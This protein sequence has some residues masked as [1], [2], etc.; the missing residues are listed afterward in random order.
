MMWSFLSYD[1]AKRMSKEKELFGKGTPEGCIASEA[2][3]NA[4]PAGTMI[5]LLTLGIPGDALSAVLLGV[6]TINGIYPGPL[7]L[8]KEPVLISTIYWS[9]LMI[10]IVSFI[11][12][13]VWLKPFAMIIKVPGKLLAISIM[14]ISMVGIYAVNTRL[15]DVGVALAM[16]V[17][18][19]ILLR[20]KWPV[21]NLVMGVVLGEIIE[22]RLRQTLSLSDGN[23]N[24]LNV[25]MGILFSRPKN[26]VRW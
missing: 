8:I 6:F 24:I 11:M 22:N 14:A 10:N 5:P 16:G 17:L 20:L 21:V 12:L 3:N 25:I 2:G 15:F 9:M 4:V 26:S 7:L 1:V 19:Y 18:G 23:I 13:A